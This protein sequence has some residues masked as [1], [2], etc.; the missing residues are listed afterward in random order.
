M[1]DTVKCPWCAEEIQA[2]AKKCKHCGE[3]V[4]DQVL[5][6]PGPSADREQESA[7]EKP[8]VGRHR[9]LDTRQRVVIVIGAVLLIVPVFL[10]VGTH[11]SAGDRSCGTV[12]SQT[13][14]DAEIEANVQEIIG[15]NRGTGDMTFD[16]RTD[17]AYVV[18]G[19]S[20][21]NDALRRVKGACADKLASLR[22]RAGLLTVGLL[23]L[24]PVV[25]WFLRPPEEERPGSQAA[26]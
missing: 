20:S 24:T 23:I 14:F 21:E 13:N 8:P 10:L 16:E 3:F 4:T 9:R 5:D 6:E 7:G 15:I 22:L 18:S 2:E 11:P 17:A 12:V 26:A 1:A 25:V 19:I